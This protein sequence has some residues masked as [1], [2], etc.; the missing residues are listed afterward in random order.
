MRK[1]S[2]SIMFRL[3]TVLL[4]VPYFGAVV[5][6]GLLWRLL[7]EDPLGLRPDSDAETYWGAHR[8]RSPRQMR[9]PW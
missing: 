3:T 5:P 6:L 8:S 4:A 2:G 9:R 7:R 1:L